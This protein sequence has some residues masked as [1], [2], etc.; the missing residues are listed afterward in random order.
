FQ[1]EDGIRDF[2]VTGVQ[3]C[4]LPISR[5]RGWPPPASPLQP[6]TSAPLVSRYPPWG[7]SSIG[8]G[9]MGAAEKEEPDPR[10]GAGRPLGE[11][12]AM[13]FNRFVEAADRLASQIPEPLLEGLTGGIQVSREERQNPDDPPDVRILGEY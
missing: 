11:G 1:A 5:H 13:T 9:G 12:R 4:A 7:L 10:P 6:W 8:K 2:H 3:T